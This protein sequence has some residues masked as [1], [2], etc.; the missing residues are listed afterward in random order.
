MQVLMNKVSLKMNGN[1]GIRDIITF[2]HFCLQ[3]KVTLQNVV[4]NKIT[5]TLI[6]TTI[7]AK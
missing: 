4:F 3:F 6:S 7:S 5:Q 2:I 1:H